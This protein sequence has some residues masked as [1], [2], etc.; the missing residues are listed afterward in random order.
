MLRYFDVHSHIHEH[1]YDSDR[2]EVI[3]RMREA[4]VQTITVGTHLKSSEAAVLLAEKEEGVFATIGLHPTDTNDSFDEKEYRS[5]A[6]SKKVVAVGE[7]G[8]DY[9][10][11]G[12]DEVEE[13]ERQKNN[14]LLQLHFAMS[15][16][17][18][19]MIHTRPSGR[20]MDAHEDMIGILREEKK[21]YGEKLSG[22]IHF[23]TGTLDV[24]RK[25]FD[26]GFSISF[27]GVLTFTTEYDSLVKES[28]VELLLSETDAPY[29]SPVPYRGRRNE[30]SFVI[31]TVKK[32]AALRGENEEVL[33]KT[34][35]ENALRIFR[36]KA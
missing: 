7:C 24:A 30:P 22:N 32:M 20:T 31:E 5:L 29:A 16:D 12:E 3:A 27:S 35:S 13:K 1:E 23:F 19:L 26:L 21:Q 14:F 36:I 25:Y 11:L 18:P 33:G 15:I 28:P 4:G 6:E 34:L 2:A 10:R 17:K 9:F 8:L